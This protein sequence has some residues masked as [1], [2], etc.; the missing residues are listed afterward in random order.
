MKHQIKGCY[1]K[2][3]V[4]IQTALKIVLQEAVYETYRK[5]LTNTINAASD[6]Q[7]FEENSLQG[8]L[9]A[10]KFEIHQLSQTFRKYY[11]ISCT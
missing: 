11:I 5:V 1:F 2:Y 3:V 6:R 10:T 9:H 8:I 4:Q 7:Y